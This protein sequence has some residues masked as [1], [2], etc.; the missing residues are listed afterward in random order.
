[1]GCDTDSSRGGQT[2]QSTLLTY[3]YTQ[4]TICRE[5]CSMAYR[6]T[7]RLIG[8]LTK[9]FKMCSAYYIHERVFVPWDERHGTNMRCHAILVQELHL[10]P[11]FRWQHKIIQMTW[12]SAS[13]SRCY[14]D[15]ST[16]AS[17]LLAVHSSR[18]H[19]LPH[20]Q[21]LNNPPRWTTIRRLIF[22]TWRKK[23]NGWTR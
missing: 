21:L 16:H 10:D 22:F 19:T 2:H 3:P 11:I 7:I 9:P 1:M 5:L 14:S 13:N 17:A 6:G 12:R 20:N 15:K 8:K 18:T 23:L 4:Y